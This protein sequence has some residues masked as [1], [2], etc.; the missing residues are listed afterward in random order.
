ME[1]FAS[2]SGI[3]QA[4][5]AGVD[6]KMRHT[7]PSLVLL[8]FMWSCASVTDSCMGV[9]FS[10]YAGATETVVGFIARARHSIR[11]AAYSFTSRPIANALISA[12]NSGVDVQ[13]VLD[14]SQQ[15]VAYSAASNVF[16]AGIPTRINYKYAIMHNKFI[17]ADGVNVETGSFNFTKA[18]EKKN[19]ENVLVLC[20]NPSVA[21]DYLTE[22][23]KLWDEAVPYEHRQ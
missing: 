14:K 2:G 15:R 12:H 22:W 23:G 18:A 20:N 19:A 13:I 9:S 10:P 11:V 3:A 7:L 6:I 17:I 8:L 21:N 1:F 16:D 5:S 4:T